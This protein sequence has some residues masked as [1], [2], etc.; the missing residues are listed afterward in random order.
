MADI[1]LDPGGAGG[2][3]GMSIGDSAL[4]TAD[5]IVSTTSATVSGVIRAGSGSAVSHAILY[6]GGG[7]VIEAIGEGVVNRSLSDA[8]E[9]ATL[10]VGYR[11]KTLPDAKAGDVVRYAM[12]WVGKKYT[13]IGALGGGARANPA[14]YIMAFGIVGF[15]IAAS[16]AL[17]SKDKFYCSQ[18]VLEAYRLAGSPIIDSTPNAS[19]PQSIVV[20]HSSGKLAYVG[21]LKA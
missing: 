4:R 2:E 12:G 3:Y 7:Q 13:V 9:H 1:P 21:H 15:G 6:I 20:A 16:G 18:L 19:S 11:V 8:L 5:L 14:L 17:R 10:A